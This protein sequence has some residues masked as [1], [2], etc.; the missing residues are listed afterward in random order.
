MS[1][2]YQRWTER[3]VSTLLKLVREG[4][5]PEDIAH[6][7]GRTARQVSVRLYNM[8]R[9]GFNVP[10]ARR[11]PQI[12]RVQHMWTSA[13]S[14]FVRDHVGLMTCSEMAEVLGLR[15]TQVVS[16]AK[17]LRRRESAGETRS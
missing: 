17:Y 1:T 16:H 10:T 7:L 6:E 13:E 14:S 2:K 9:S 11:G 3:E 5:R 8:R 12:G 15:V 4:K